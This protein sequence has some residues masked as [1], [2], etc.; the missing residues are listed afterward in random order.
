VGTREEFERHREA[1]R[2]LQ[3]AI[4]RSERELTEAQTALKDF[5]QSQPASV[6]AG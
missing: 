3:T 2:E 5:E 6:R 1:Q 4:S